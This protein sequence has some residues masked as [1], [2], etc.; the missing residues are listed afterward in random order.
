MK[1]LPASRISQLTV[2]DLPSAFPPLRLETPLVPATERSAGLSFN[3]LLAR[4]SPHPAALR[5]EPACR[6]DFLGE[7]WV[8][9][10]G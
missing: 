4:R 5:T 3:R 9:E 2:P 7:V 1:G 10:R 6:S 8:N